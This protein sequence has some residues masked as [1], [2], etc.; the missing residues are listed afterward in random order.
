MKSLPLTFFCLAVLCLSAC[1]NSARNDAALVAVASNFRSTF[2]K[3]ET[4]FEA[5]TDFDVTQVSGSTGSIYT[6]I[7]NGAPY[8]IFLA[9][10]QSRAH[11]LEQKGLASARFTYAEGALVLWSKTDDISTLFVFDTLADPDVTPIAI[12]NPALAPYGAAA[13]QT[14]NSLNISPRDR[15][16]IGEN[17]GQ[18]FALVQSGN[19]AAGFVAKSDAQRFPAGHYAVIDP[20][21]YAPIKQDAVMLK[22]GERREAAKAFYQFLKSPRA[23]AIIAADGYQRGAV[24]R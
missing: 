13:M 6:K 5:E 2:D 24:T 16:V 7:L 14:F 15:L 3:L 12:A 19:A 23:A 10:D 22:K 1:K 18:A 9:A 21:L 8:H 4:A 17:V 20:A 11:K